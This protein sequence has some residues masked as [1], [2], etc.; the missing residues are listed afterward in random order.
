MASFRRESRRTPRS[1]ALSLR[2]MGQ[3][4]RVFEVLAGALAPSWIQ[5]LSESALQSYLRALTLATYAPQRRFLA[6]RL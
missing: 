2:P 6:K 5:S 1:S 4:S 3:E